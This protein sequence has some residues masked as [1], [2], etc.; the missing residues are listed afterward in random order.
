MRYRVQEFVLDLRKFEL[1]KGTR[2]VPIEPQVLALLFLLIE[3]RDRLVTKDELIASVWQGR[4]VSDSAISSRIKS[5]RHLLGDDGDAQRM[6]RTIHGKGFRFVGEVAACDTAVPVERAGY[7]GGQPSIAVLPFECPDPELA[8]I[9]DGVPHEL[10]VGLSRRRSL[11]VIARGSSFRFRGWPGDIAQV[12][13][14]LGVR[15]CLTGAV[16]RIGSQLAVAVELVDARSGHVV[17]GEVYEG[18]VDRLHETRETILAQVISSLELHISRHEA[19]LARF[20][21]ADDLSA[22]SAYHVGL[23]HLYRFNKADNAQALCYFEHAARRDPCFTGAHAGISFARFQNAFMR[24]T[25]RPDDEVKLARRAA[26]RAIELDEQDPAANL[27]LGRSLW[28]DRQVE[29]SVPWLERSIALSPNYAQAIYSLAWTQ[30]IL[31]QGKAGQ[32]NARAALSLSPVDPLR[33]AMMAIDGFTQT[34]SEDA[35]AGALLV[36][37]AAREPRAHVMIAV[38]A[39]ICHAWAGNADRTAYWAQEIRLRRPDLTKETFLGS[40]PYREG[41][42]R[43]RVEEVLEIIGI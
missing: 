29:S 19:E 38:M 5:A 25:D 18:Q 7:N 21:A 9:C 37:Q 43:Q 27:M 34:L 22:W 3:N 1:R 20:G 30:M 31:C 14:I 16:H 32:Q 17:W 8:T 41:P 26:E 42:V 4:S 12:A 35:R 36:D 6:I 2:L 40:F 23:Q 15:F 24:Y 39:A 33:Y 10:I 28:L 11:K 13:D